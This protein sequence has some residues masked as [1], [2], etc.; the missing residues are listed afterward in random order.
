VAVIFDGVYAAELD[1]W[2]F[3]SQSF[4]PSTKHFWIPD[5]FFGGAGDALDLTAVGQGVSAGETLFVDTYLVGVTLFAKKGNSTWAR[6]SAEAGGDEAEHRVLGQVLA[7]ASPPNNLG[8][9]QF[10]FDNVADIGA[11]A[12]GAGFGFGQQGTAA[13]AFYDFPNPPMT[14]PVAITSNEPV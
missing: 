7:G 1:H 12:A 14:P 5:G 3:I 9:E 2:N 4:Q 10:P 8:F 13:G 6:Y 11:A